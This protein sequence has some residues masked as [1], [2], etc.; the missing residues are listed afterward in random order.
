MRLLGTYL[1]SARAYVA[2]VKTMP[3]PL[4]FVVGRLLRAIRVSHLVTFR[5]DDMRLRLYPSVNSELYWLKRDIHL[6]DHRFLRQ[7]VRPGDTVVDVGANIGAL[8]VQASILVGNAGRV[9]A[10][11]AHP[12]T[13]RYLLGNVRLN[14]CSNIQPINVAVGASQ[15]SVNI[16]DFPDRDDQNRVVAVGTSVPA[17]SLDQL[18][19]GTPVSLLKID[20]EG[21]EKFVLEGAKKTLR[22]TRCVY[23]QSFEQQFIEYGYHTS[24]VLRLLEDA[25]LTVLR[26]IDWSRVEPDYTSASVENLVALRDPTLV[27]GLEPSSGFGGREALRERGNDTRV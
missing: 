19:G 22:V 8:A 23:I 27:A 3:D 10:L 16:S 25:G 17:D 7:V 24:D 15:G 21:F 11:E 1:R 4:R 6:S 5:V 2:M 14:G 26:H 18:L 20:V 12:R 9:I 13:Y